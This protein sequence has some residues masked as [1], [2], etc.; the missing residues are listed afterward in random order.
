MGASS[1]SGGS[2]SKRCQHFFVCVGIAAAVAGIVVGFTI[3]QDADLLRHDH[4][5]LGP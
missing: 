1:E 5:R 4:R 2:K 3:R